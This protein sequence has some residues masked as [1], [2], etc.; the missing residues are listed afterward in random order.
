MVETTKGLLIENSHGWEE[1]GLER[2][3]ATSRET[4]NGPQEK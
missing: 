3:K 4:N 1:G 2:N